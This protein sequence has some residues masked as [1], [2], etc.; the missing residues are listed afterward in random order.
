LGYLLKF[1]FITYA[2]T[3]ACFIT[4][5][6]ISH[7]LAPASPPFTLASGFLVFLGTFAPSLV[8]LGLTAHDE[9]LPG[10]RA[11]LRRMFQWQVGVR[12]YVFA[13]VYLPAI[14]LCVAL[15]HRVVTSSWPRFGTESWF[16]IMAAIVISTPF[17]AGEEIGWRGYALPRLADRLGFAWASIVLGLIWSTWHLPIFFIRGAD[18]YGQSFPVWTLQV[19]GLSVAIAWLYVHTKGSLLLTMLMH[20]A[21]NQTVGIVPSANSNPGNPFALNVT[22]VMWLTAAFLWITALYFLVRMPGVGIRSDKNL[23]GV[24]ADDRGSKKDDIYSDPCSSV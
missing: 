7:G 8:A 4:V 2:L 11:L 14:K 12:W 1:F 18:K 3:W 6:R 9:G 22:L 24:Y 21:V 20:S 23:P 16:I 19:V 5:A 17:Q 10:V 15:V 13:I